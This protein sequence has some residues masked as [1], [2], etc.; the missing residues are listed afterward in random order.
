M[1]RVLNVES[2][3]PHNAT[4]VKRHLSWNHAPSV[5]CHLQEN[6]A[7]RGQHKRIQRLQVKCNETLAYRTTKLKK[8]HA[9]NT[10]ATPNLVI[11]F[12]LRQHLHPILLKLQACVNRKTITRARAK[13]TLTTCSVCD[14]YEVQWFCQLTLNAIAKTSLH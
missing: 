14:L 3:T 7:T 5:T 13:K 4:K 1:R 6:A 11:A 9:G 10:S 8:N 2:H 12:Q